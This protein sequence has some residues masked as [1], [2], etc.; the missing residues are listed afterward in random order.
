M[1]LD[2]NKID[3]KQLRE[4]KETLTEAGVA[5]SMTDRERGARYLTGINGIIHLLDYIQDSAVEGGYK[6]E[7]EVFGEDSDC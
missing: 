2:E 7:Q 6:T 5:V 3:W 4:Q 1:Y